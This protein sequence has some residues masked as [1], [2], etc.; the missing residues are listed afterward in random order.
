MTT[1]TAKVTALMPL[2]GY[3][4]QFLRESVDSVLQQTSGRWKLNIIVERNDLRKFQGILSAALLD[5]RVR[6]IANTGRKL[7]G[8][9]NAGMHQAD[10]EFVAILLADDMWAQNA[11]EVLTQAIVSH[12][13]ADFFHSSRRYIDERSE[14]ISSVY[15]CR[16]QV[17]LADFRHCAPVKHLLCWRRS[18]ALSFGGL[19]ETLD[20]VGPDDFDFPWTMAEKGARFRAVPE[21][22]Y[23]YREHD[24]CFRLTT[25]LPLSVHKKEIARILRKHGLQEEEIIRRVAEGEASYLKQCIYR[26]R[27][28]RWLNRLSLRRKPAFERPVYR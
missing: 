22:L 3:Q 16:K 4:P 13:E 5:E 12:P 19:D 8:A 7:A 28:H 21:C 2:R 14:F 24:E 25:G 26:T 23:Y 27:L 15:E 6:M 10:T 9:I 11:I 20:S 18:L 17:V 1:N